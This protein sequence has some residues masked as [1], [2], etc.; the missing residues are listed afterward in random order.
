VDANLLN[1]VEQQHG[2]FAAAVRRQRDPDEF[3][4][5]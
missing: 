3:D 1:D 4:A 2:E 5:T